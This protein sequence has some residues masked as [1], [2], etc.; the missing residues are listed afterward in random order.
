MATWMFSR[1]RI[2]DMEASSFLGLESTLEEA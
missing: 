1:D 2:E